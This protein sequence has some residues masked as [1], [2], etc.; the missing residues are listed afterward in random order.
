MKKVLVLLIAIVLV[1]GITAA[2]GNKGGGAAD[3]GETYKVAMIVHEISSFTDAFNRGAQNGA[4]CFGIEVDFMAPDKIDIPKQ[5]AMLES[6]V[7]SDQYAAVATT[8]LDD[9]AYTA[10]IDQAKAKGMPVVIFNA[11][12]TVAPLGDAYVGQNSVAAGYQVAKAVFEKMGG[13]GKYI[14]VSAIPTLGVLVQRTEG[15]EKAA[16]EY[17]GIELAGPQIDIGTDMTKAAAAVENAFTAYPDVNGVI[18]TDHF[19][20]SIGMYQEAS[21]KQGTVVAGGFDLTPGI[22]NY[23]K[24]GAMQVSC[25]QNPFMQGFYPIQMFYHKLY[26]DI[27]PVLEIDTGAVIVTAENVERFI[28]SGGE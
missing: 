14:S 19:S 3:S 17:P 26:F 10:A 11:D 16:A 20:E 22:L 1:V 28:A 5:V 15:I 13:T 4:E 23:I 12:S 18:G 9:N 27:D 7:N 24:T 2:C 6:A 21:G 25:G 8:I